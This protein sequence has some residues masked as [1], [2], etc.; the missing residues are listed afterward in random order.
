MEVYYILYTSSSQALGTFAVH[1]KDL[2]LLLR[3]RLGAL[4]AQKPRQRQQAARGPQL[5][6]H[7]EEQSLVQVPTVAAQ[8]RLG[9]GEGI[10]DRACFIG[11]NE[12]KMNGK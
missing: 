5:P 10:F 4:E 1:P 12:W 2:L 11:G 3:H 6:G 7:P 8:H 9:H